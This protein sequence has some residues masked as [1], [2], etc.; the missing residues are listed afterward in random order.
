MIF[1]SIDV[2]KSYIAF[3]QKCLEL[4]TKVIVQS[5]NHAIHCYEIGILKDQN[6]AQVQPINHK[7]T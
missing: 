4:E 6:D 1:S 2:L 5:A 7:I 3:L